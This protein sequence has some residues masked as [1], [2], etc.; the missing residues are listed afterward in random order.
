MSSFFHSNDVYFFMYI[1]CTI[2]DVYFPCF[3]VLHCVNIL[4]QFNRHTNDNCWVLLDYGFC[5]YCCYKLC[6]K[7]FF[8]AT[9]HIFPLRIFL[10]MEL[11]RYWLVYLQCVLLGNFPSACI[12]GYLYQQHSMRFPVALHPYQ[13]FVSSVIFNFTNLGMSIME[14]RCSFNLYFLIEHHFIVLL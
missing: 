1:M 14:L 3:R 4:N 9:T 13:S 5:K 10:G 8:R 12:I 2:I 7:C 11:L 6:S